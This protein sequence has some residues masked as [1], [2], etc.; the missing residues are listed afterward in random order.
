MYPRAAFIFAIRASARCAVLGLAIA[1]SARV[2]A[3]APL[4]PRPPAP[5]DRRRRSVIRLEE[6]IHPRLGLRRIGIE[7]EGQI[8]GA[9]DVVGPAAGHLRRRLNA[10]K[11]L[12]EKLDA[13]P[14]RKP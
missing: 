1:T 2:W 14:G 4:P 5:V 3:A 9:D 12:G 8:G 6:L 10:R 11:V 7:R 13:R